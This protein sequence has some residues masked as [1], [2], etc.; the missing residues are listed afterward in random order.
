MTLPLGQVGATAPN[1]LERTSLTDIVKY[2]HNQ[3]LSQFP[4]I[5]LFDEMIVDSEQVMW[6]TVYEL[7]KV[8]DLRIGPEAGSRLDLN[9][10]KNQIVRVFYQAYTF[11]LDT[12]QSILIQ[13]PGQPFASGSA[14]NDALVAL[15]NSLAQRMRVYMR[16]LHQVCVSILS[17]TAAT[18]TVKGVTANLNFGVETKTAAASWGTGST[19]ILTELDGWL[20]DFKKENEGMAANVVIVNDSFHSDYIIGNTELRAT[21]APYQQA[22][23]MRGILKPLFTVSEEETPLRI[24]KVSDM[25]DPVGN[26]DFSDFTDVWPTE[27]M[28]L[29]RIEPG[30]QNLQLLSAR[31]LDNANQGG[32]ASYSWESKNPVQVEVTVCGNHVPVIKKPGRVKI[33]D[34][35]P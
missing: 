10:V 19:D 4:L 32:I 7:L 9:L 16:T 29:L 30:E 24:I 33:H 1:M 17:T 25:I 15:N 27:R 22:G 31:T 23:F 13:Q 26:G 34:L 2:W 12:N 14:A 20:R 3:Y 11:D 6:N 18:V 28:T 8:G 5:S 35:V 21:F